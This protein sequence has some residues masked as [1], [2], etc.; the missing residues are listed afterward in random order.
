M[1]TTQL[2]LVAFLA[3]FSASA[4]RATT[5]TI[6]PPGDTPV[7]PAQASA[8][9][10]GNLTFDDEFTTST[11]WTTSGS[12]TSGY[13]WYPNFWATATASQ[14]SV[15]TG[16]VYAVNGT[17]TST[18][19]ASPTA[20]QT[21]TGVMS[22]VG[23]GN[24]SSVPEYPNTTGMGP[25]PKLTGSFNH[26]YYEARIQMAANAGGQSSENAFWSWSTTQFYNN[27]ISSNYGTIS[28]MDFMEWV[29]DTYTQ[30]S[31]TYYF[32]GCNTLHN[33]LNSVDQSNTNAENTMDSTPAGSPGA[34]MGDGNFHTYGCL[35]V[36]TS[37][38]TGYVQNY[39]DNQL[40]T[41]GGGVTRFLTGVGTGSSNGSVS[42]VG[43]V[44]CYTPSGAGL[45]AQEASNMFLIISGETGWPINI[46]WVHVWQAGS[47]ST[48]TSTTGT[49]TQ[50]V[51][52]FGSALSLTTSQS[53]YTLPATTSAGLTLTYSVASGP[54][55]V[56]GNTLTLTGAGTVNLTATQ[57]GNSTYAPYSGSETITVTAPSQSTQTISNFPATLNLTTTQSPYTL[58]ATSSAGLTVAYTVASG[59]ATVKGNT[60]TLTGPG[61]VVVDAFQAGNSSYIAYSAIETITVTSPGTQT[62]S[63]FPLTLS[64]TTTQSPYTLPATTTAGLT[65]TYTVVSGPG[66]VSGNTLTLT[67]AGTVVLNAKQA[68]NSSYAAYAGTETISVTE[69]TQTLT[70]FGSALSLSM[71]QSPYTLPAQTSAGLAVTYKVSSGPATVSGD[72]LTLTGS[73]SV[74]VAAS[75]AGNSVYAPFSA[76]ETITV[77]PLT[78][79]TVSGFPSTLSLVTTASPYALPSTTSA[80]LTITYA[81]VSGPGSVSGHTLTLT[82]AGTVVVTASQAGNS[83]YAAY[84]GEEA[85]TVTAATQSITGFPSAMSLTMGQTPYT[86]PATTSAGLTPTYTVSSGPATVS[87]H[88]LSLTGAGTVVVAAKQ[89]GTAMYAAYS[90]TETITVSNLT[91]QTVSNFPSTLTETLGVTPVSL[92]ADTSAGQ[93]ITYTVASGPATISGDT[94][95]FTGSGTV[96]IDASAAG[97]SS[98]AAYTGV[99]T[100]TVSAGA[101]MT[102]TQWEALYFTAAQMANAAVSGPTAMPESDQVPNLLK[103]LYDINP[104]VPMTTAEYAA[105][106]AT[107]VDTTTTPGTTYLTVTYRQYAKVTGITVQVQTSTDMQNW[108][109][110]TPNISKQIGTDSTTG[111]P[112]IED[113]VATTST[114][115]FVRLNVTQP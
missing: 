13:N 72:T 66:T 76:S 12:A 62:L 65:V 52:G 56:S 87:G 40:I 92:T 105:M 37:A 69:A 101:T 3:A 114:T 27:T 100:I 113:E 95:T 88:T 109:T 91:A 55:T 59:P 97:N 25:N 43:G 68:G 47:S 32:Y 48:G 81:V 5:T 112:I 31:K 89:A 50:T 74:V 67:G 79:Q 93:A 11:T 4:S 63:G 19:P 111:D 45:T 23:G 28:E 82:G 2:L 110:V 85:I 49:V 18:A 24:L 38:T 29:P 86:L 34:I 42:T 80:G 9:G 26:A 57:A 10:F 14:V 54:A 75:Q 35:W 71:G 61:T 102:F 51:S 58:P 106:A 115:E 17:L 99:E 46:D 20:A 39:L 64:L 77:A 8:V 16:T 96:V 21:A 108:T 41:H 53:P 44:T 98:Y 73:G 103:Y 83:T 6:I 94:V 15:T 104:A 30:S 36:A 60:L 33:W 84:S 7:C 78:A 70:G 90:G 1:K 22:I 107:D